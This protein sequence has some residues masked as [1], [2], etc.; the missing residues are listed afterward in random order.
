[1]SLSAVVQNRS[2]CYF[3]RED[4]AVTYPHIYIKLSKNSGGV[5]LICGWQWRHQ[6]FLSLIEEVISGGGEVQSFN[7]L[8]TLRLHTEIWPLPFNSSTVQEGEKVQSLFLKEAFQSD[9]REVNWEPPSPGSLENF[10]CDFPHNKP[11]AAAARQSITALNRACLK[12][13]TFL[14]VAP[15]KH[16]SRVPDV[17]D[18]LV[19][20]KRQRFWPRVNLFDTNWNTVFVLLIEL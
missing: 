18:S 13:M 17:S 6:R 20:C 3:P 15:Y 8:I 2:H 14:T 10:S 1:M 16:L 7:I 11:A 9:S 4:L 5:N 12:L 19:T